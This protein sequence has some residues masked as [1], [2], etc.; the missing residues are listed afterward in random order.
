MD[1]G[2]EREMRRIALLIV[3]LSMGWSVSSAFAVPL[4]GVSYEGDIYKVDQVTGTHQLF[5]VNTGIQW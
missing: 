3:C 1:N 2:K 4:Y 5:M